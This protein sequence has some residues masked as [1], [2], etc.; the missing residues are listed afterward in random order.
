MSSS[1]PCCRDNNYENYSNIP[2]YILRERAEELI[3]I[4]RRNNAPVELKQLT[5]RLKKIDD[6]LKNK[7]SEYKEFKKE[8]KEIL[9]NDKKLRKQIWNIQFTKQKIKRRIGLFQSNDYPLPYL[10]IENNYL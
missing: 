1:C 4:S 6:K 7:N 2:A 9:S 8:N 10:I 3:K 5:H